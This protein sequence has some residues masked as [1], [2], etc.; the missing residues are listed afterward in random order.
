MEVVEIKEKLDGHLGE[1]GPSW[2][3]QVGSGASLKVSGLWG[4]PVS[5]QGSPWL[6]EQEFA[7]MGPTSSPATPHSSTGDPS[8]QSGAT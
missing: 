2:P 5:G 7:S 6:K 1:C 3:V 8:S 4:V